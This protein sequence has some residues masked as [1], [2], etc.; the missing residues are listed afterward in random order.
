[1][2][3]NDVYK[4]CSD[5]DSDDPKIKRKRKKKVKEVNI[6]LPRGLFVFNNPDK[7]SHEGYE[8][9]QN[10][11]RFP[12]PFRCCILG[13]VNSGKTLM[14]LNIIIARQSHYPKFEE[15][16]IVHGCES[17]HEYDALEPTEIMTEI[18]SYT[19]FDPQTPKLIIIDDYDFTNIDKESKKRLSELFRFGSTHCN[20]SIILLHQ[21]W[22]RVPKI[23]KDMCNVFIIYKPHDSDELHTIGRRVGIDKVQTEYLFREFITNTKDSI[24]INL[25]PNAPNK[26]S[27]N[28][29][30]KIEIPHNLKLTSE[31]IRTK[32][33]R[34]IDR[35]P[36]NQNNVKAS[37]DSDSSSDDDSGH[38]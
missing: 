14:C 6:S 22:F 17:S 24:M 30:E 5:S 18:P 16:Y 20:F 19:E 37:S 4:Y 15:I 23:V 9:G 26:F 29:Y 32:M 1:M 33:K 25:I 2:L 7:I 8:P 11:I 36:K 35:N 28:L 12:L 10:P 3:P 21:S 27:R 13:Q 34:R 38:R 31:K